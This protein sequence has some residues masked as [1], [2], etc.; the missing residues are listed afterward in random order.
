MIL[1]ILV[2]AR[3]DRYSVPCFN[4]ELY[5]SDMCQILP[6]RPIDMHVHLEIETV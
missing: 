5:R 2:T 1:I 4:L 3:Y 6:L